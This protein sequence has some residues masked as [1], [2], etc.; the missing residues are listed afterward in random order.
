MKAFIAFWKKDIINKL[1]VFVSFVLLGGAF[2]VAYLT[3]NMKSDSMF[4]AI[5]SSAFGEYGVPT[6]AVA[7]TASVTETPFAFPTNKPLPVSPTPVPS[8]PTTL[9]PID[10]ESPATANPTSTAEVVMPTASPTLAKATTVPTQ[11]TSDGVACIPANPAQTGKVLDVIDGNTVKVLIDGIAYTVR[12]LGIDVPKYKP[13]AEYFGQES[14]FKNA[15]YVFAEQITLIAD[16]QDK[17]ENGRLLR[18]V[19]VGDI[20]VN[21]ELVRHG[22][23]IASPASSACAEVFKAAE[24]VAFQ[25]RIGLWKPT[26]TLP[27]P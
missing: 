9:P 5:Y 12:Y 11:P 8:T 3:M 23:A 25:S 24:Q 6:M 13:L 4:Y 15:E 20:F 10:T 27:S 17:D 26:P 1:I 21:Y 22:F 18:Y 2:I 14:D 7:S 19:K 16:I